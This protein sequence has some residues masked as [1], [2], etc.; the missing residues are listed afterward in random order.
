MNR[1][2]AVFLTL[3][4]VVGAFLASPAA[5]AAPYLTG[6]Q[7]L[8][9]VVDTT[10]KALKVEPVT[11]GASSSALPFF[12]D[13]VS[14]TSVQVKASGAAYLYALNVVNTT[15]ATA[16]LQLFGT[17]TASLGTT[18]PTWVVRVPG[19][20]SVTFASSLPIAIAGSGLCLGGTTTSTGGTPAVLSVSLGYR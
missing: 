7:V 1:I 15:G 9:S 4:L 3:A 18:S 5:K 2:S 12:N 8:N 17:A 19:T 13:S 10:N 11:G 20:S 14:T 6:D 16:Y